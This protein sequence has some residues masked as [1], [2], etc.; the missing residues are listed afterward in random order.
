MTPV[1]L[2][3]SGI[4]WAARLQNGNGVIFLVSSKFADALD[5]AYLQRWAAELSVGDLL[6]RALRDAVI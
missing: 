2:D 1:N 5:R 3:A 4:A 6:E